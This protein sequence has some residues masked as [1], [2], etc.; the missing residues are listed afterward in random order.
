MANKPKRKINSAR[1]A[2]LVI[3]RRTLALLLVF[4]VASFLALFA[5]AYDL[6]INQYDEMKERASNQQMRSTVISASRG[7]ILDRNGTVLAMSASADNI[8]LDPNSIQK[9]ADALDLARAEAM[10]EGVKEGESLPMSGQEYKDMIAVRLSEILDMDE[11]KVREKMGRTKS[12]YEVL[13]YRVEKDVS[14]QVREFITNN[15]SGAS[16][17]GVHLETDAKRY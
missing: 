2:K 13:K 12:M 10:V 8:F 15:A 4:G 14:D 9:R 1:L 5:K 6:T 11:E 16:L 7:S 17:Q 3:Q